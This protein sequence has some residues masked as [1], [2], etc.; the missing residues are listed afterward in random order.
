MGER[1]VRVCVRSTCAM[2]VCAYLRDQP[3]ELVSLA[4][5]RTCTCCYDQIKG[6]QDK[7]VSYS[8]SDSLS[9]A[10]SLCDASVVS[11]QWQASTDP[12]QQASDK[13]T[14][15]RTRILRLSMRRTAGALL[16]FFHEVFVDT[17]SAAV[18]NRV[19]EGE[20]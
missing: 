4:L 13:D 6:T 15:R 14:K 10:P 9:F 16:R 2:S 7:D 18:R 5:F 8:F 3:F 11:L 17:G 1:E 19:I 20:G 12:A